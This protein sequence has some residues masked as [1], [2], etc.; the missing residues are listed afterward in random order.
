MMWYASVNFSSFGC[1][2]LKRQQKVIG[3]CKQ[4]PYMRVLL[5]VGKKGNTGTWKMLTV[6]TGDCKIQLKGE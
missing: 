4:H 1:Y 6:A 5:E 2:Y 3:E